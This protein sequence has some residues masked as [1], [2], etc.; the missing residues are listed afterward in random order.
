[1]RP[2]SPRVP[3]GLARLLQVLLRPNPLLR[4]F[5]RRLEASPRA[6]AVFTALEE[7]VKRA[8]FG[9]RMCA[10]CALPVTSYACPMTCPKELRNGPCGGVRLDGG[11]EVYPERRCV[12]LV[13]YERAASEDR[14]GDLRRFQFPIDQRKWG[15]SS[16]VNYWLGRDEGL[17]T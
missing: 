11:C 10:Q 2:V 16:W 15:R 5:A 12:W 13:A 14:V 8:G 3:L 6:Y 9:C 7:R 17:W 1:M 4:A